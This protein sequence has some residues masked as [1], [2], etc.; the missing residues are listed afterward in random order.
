[1]QTSDKAIFQGDHLTVPSCQRQILWHC[2]SKSSS[3]FLI[4]LH[5]T[6]TWTSPRLCHMNVICVFC[7]F[8][9]SS[10]PYVPYNSVELDAI[11]THIQLEMILNNIQYYPISSNQYPNQHLSPWDE[12]YKPRSNKEIMQSYRDWLV[13]DLPIWKI[14]VRQ[15]GLQ[16]PIYG[17][18]KKHVPNF[19]TFPN[20]Q[21]ED[22]SSPQGLM[23]GTFFESTVWYC[24]RN[25]NH[26]LIG[27]KHPTISR[28]S[29]KVVQ[30]F[31]SACAQLQ[32]T[33]NPQQLYE[34][35]C[36]TRMNIEAS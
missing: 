22:F 16:F 33:W 11:Y 9:V 24:E 21:P 34:M 30:D 1:M 6:N 2:T 35:Q 12:I 36:E 27:G 26:Q 10:V 19:Q 3:S 15:L 25:P 28:L 5:M 31:V 32:D 17:K 29:T 14:W 4:L 13:V 18:S 8:L 23:C 20:H 7:F